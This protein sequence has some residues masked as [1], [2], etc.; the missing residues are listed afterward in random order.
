MDLDEYYNA[1]NI[2]KLI[3]KHGNLKLWTALTDAV[4]FVDIYEAFKD[5][6]SQK[7]PIGKLK[8]IIEGPFFSWEEDTNANNIEARNTLF[9]LE[10]AARL[11]KCGAEITGFDDVDFLFDNVKFNA[12]CK[13]FHSKKNVEYNV[14]K[15]AEQFAKKMGDGE[16]AKGIICLSLDKL[17]GIEDKI[18]KVDSSEEIRAHLSNIFKHFTENHGYTWHNL[19]N[20]NILAV[21]VFVHAIAH[22]K[23]S[24]HN[25]H[26]TC[27][28][29][30]IS[31]TDLPLQFADS[32]LIKRLGLALKQNKRKAT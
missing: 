13:R 22:K 28:Q 25:L 11:K 24:P 7:R 4:A 21:L 15:A 18:L 12:Q 3:D 17:T 9:E 29:V 10:A 6:D 19:I 31:M 5:Q 8:K 1:N 2:D 27:C 32:C 30:D 23:N 26:T 20:I 16:A 14:D